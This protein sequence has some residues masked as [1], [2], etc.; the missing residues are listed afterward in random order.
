[1][2]A[3]PQLAADHAQNCKAFAKSTEDLS[4]ELL[5]RSMSC[6]DKLCMWSVIG[7]QGGLAAP[8]LLEPVRLATCIVGHQT[9]D[10]TAM[11]RGLGGRLLSLPGW[12]DDSNRIMRDAKVPMALSTREEFSSSREVVEAEAMA[13]SGGGG[14]GGGGGGGKAG[15]K[16]GCNSCGSSIN[17]SASVGNLS[18][19]GGGGGLG[20]GVWEATVGGTGAKLGATKKTQATDAALSR[21][22]KLSMFRAETKLHETVTAEQ[23]PYS[24]AKRGC[25]EY[26]SA[27][28]R[29][30]EAMRAVGGWVGN[31]DC[32]LEEFDA[33]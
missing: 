4:A 8:Y 2:L 28:A 18:W 25:D 22:S 6:S 13:R 31:K 7:L 27:K 11:T 26:C 10:S 3:R 9:F 33:H 12:R 16:V 20:G 29:V 19:G 21:L 1:M 30:I 15:G 14:E 5:V 24:K 32:H 23:R 17:W